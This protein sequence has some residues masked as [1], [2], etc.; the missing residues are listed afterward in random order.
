VI[1]FWLRLFFQ[2]TAIAPGLVRT[3]KP[4][5][6]R[7]AWW[8]APR[9]RRGTD[10]N[11]RRIFDE[12]LDGPQLRNFSLAV[13][14]YFYE[15][16]FDVGRSLR[17]SREELRGRIVSVEGHENYAAARASRRGAILL[18]AHMG[19]FELGIVALSQMNERVHVVFRRDRIVGFERLRSALHQQLGVMEA[20]LDDK[21][22]VWLRLRDA[23]RA[24]E[25]VAIQGD[26]VMPGQNGVDMPFFKG[27][28][29]LPTGP[30]KLASASAAP[31][32]PVFTVRAPDGR[33]RIFVEEAIDVPHPLDD[34]AMADA[35]QKI[36]RVLEKYVKAYPEQWLVFTPAFSED[37]A[38][39]E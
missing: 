37:R 26:R 4:V 28:L 23:L 18:T 39:S 1:A 30:V 25:V 13:I 36:S 33:V 6:V 27:H 20:A 21:W 15:F 3:L 5:F 31:I 14:G 9:I 11:A 8:F 24:D 34:Q 16:V 38:N 35:M 2:L 19:S 10:A 17:A 22:T 29:P 7:L 32:I 12:P